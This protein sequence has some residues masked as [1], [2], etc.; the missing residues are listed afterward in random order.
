MQT[1]GDAGYLKVQGE[2]ITLH[3]KPILLKGGFQPANPF[4]IEC[5]DL[6][7]YS[8][9][10]ASGA[11]LGGWSKSYID[12]LL[13]RAGAQIYPPRSEYGELHHWL[14]WT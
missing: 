1:N 6:A 5:L 14:S 4:I 3:G 10:L 8:S 12:E 7:T 13:R 2:H 11:G 9:F